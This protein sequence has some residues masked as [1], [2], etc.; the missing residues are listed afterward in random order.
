MEIDYLSVLTWCATIQLTRPQNQSFNHPID[1]PSY[2]STIQSSTNQP[3]QIAGA[4]LPA[5]AGRHPGLSDGAGR[6]RNVRRDPDAE[7]EGAGLAHPRAARVSHL[8]LPPVRSAG[9]DIRA[10]AARLSKGGLVDW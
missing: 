2:Q 5:G 9:Q 8:R 4:H 7:D 10:H 3:T 6:D 1:Q